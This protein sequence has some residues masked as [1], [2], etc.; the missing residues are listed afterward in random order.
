MNESSQWHLDKRVPVSLIATIILQ[1]FAFGWM[2]AGIN[3]K[4]DMNAASIESL[5]TE[6]Q[7]RRPIIESNAISVAVLNQHLQSIAENQG[8]ILR[9]IERL[10]GHGK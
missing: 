9:A 3:A 8:E 1:T 2:A 4:A 6:L 7:L 10:E 5:K